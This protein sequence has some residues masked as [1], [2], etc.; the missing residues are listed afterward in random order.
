MMRNHYYKLMYYSSD[1][2][3][4]NLYFGFFIEIHYS[5]T[6]IKKYDK[7]YTYIYTLLSLVC[8]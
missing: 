3:V 1:S 5:F 7:Y 8:V 2:E 4:G 6:N